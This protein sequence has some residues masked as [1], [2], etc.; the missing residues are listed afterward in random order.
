MMYNKRK[1]AK[2][3]KKDRINDSWTEP[4]DEVIVS[5]ASLSAS[6]SAVRVLSNIKLSEKQVNKLLNRDIEVEEVVT[7]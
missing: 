3:V 6:T 7:K 5:S 2:F 1:M 4:I